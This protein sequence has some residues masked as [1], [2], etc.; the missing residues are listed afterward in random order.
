MRLGH[1]NYEKLDRMMNKGLV[2]GLP[3]FQ[4]QS[5]LVCAGCQYG[6][7][8]QLPYKPATVHSKGPLD[9]VHTDVF[10]PVNKKSIGGMVYMIEFIDDY[11]KFVWVYFMQSKSEALAKFKEFRLVAERE[12]GR[13]VKVLRSDNGGEYMS[14]EFN[15]FL[16]DC[17]IGRQL[18]CPYTPQQNG[19]SER[20]NRHLAEVSGSLMHSKNVPGQFWA[21]AMQTAAYVTNRLPQQ[22]L[23]FLTPYEKLYKVKPTVSHFRVFGCV[24][25]VFVPNN[26]RH[27]LE[28][29]AIRCI[30]VGY[31]NQR[32][33]WKCCD[34]NT[35]KCYVS[36]NV[37]FDETSSWWSAEQKI[38]PDSQP[39]QDELQASKVDLRFEVTTPDEEH[40]ESVQHQEG[41]GVEELP[42]EESGLRRS[43]RIRRQNPRYANVAISEETLR[44]PESFEEASKHHGWMLAMES[45][46]AALISNQTWELVPLPVDVKPIT[47]KW[48][49]KIKR[50][51]D[52]TVERL[53]ARLV[54][55][56]FTQQ[57]GFDYE[58]TFS[59]V[60]KITTVRMILALAV[61][62][63]W[64]LYQMDVH[65]AFLYGELDHV[66]HMEQPIGFV[67]SEH[68]KIVCKLKKAIYGLKQSP[69]AWYGKISE[70]LEHNGFASTSADASLFVKVLGS[71][72]AIVLVYVDDL[73]I[74]GDHVEVITQLKENLKTRF[75]M[76]D[77]GLLRHF[78]GLEVNY[79]KNGLLLH[80]SQYV[81]DLIQRFRME[82]S[83]AAAT[84]FEPSLRLCPDEGKEAEDVTEYRQMIGSLIYLTLTRPDISFAVG[85]LS[86]FMQ[87]PRKPHVF[88]ARRI[89]RYL[90]A[91]TGVGI[92]FTKTVSPELVGF[93]D[94]DYAGDLSMRRSTTGYVFMYG[95][96]PISWS[97]KLQPTVSLSTAE[98]EYRAAAMAA[99][100]LVWLIQ[101]LKDT[102]QRVVQ[103]VK[104][105]SDNRSAIQ[106]A[107]NPTFHARTKHIE[108]H[109]HFVREK[110]LT[111]DIAL[112]Y[113]DTNDQVADMLTKGL[114]VHKLKK[115]CK[116]LGL[117]SD[118]VEGEC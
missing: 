32:K 98:A 8:H 36:R 66:I 7:A 60:A 95:M 20:K 97:S 104:L 78:L 112:E 84:P 18:T 41:G 6:K 117:K 50:K 102:G 59:P 40:D 81:K 72:V 73:I 82:N 89:L 51:T 107:E 86:I 13:K 108:V 11:S 12:T 64:K 9:L 46:V 23:N 80:Q 83:K 44:E 69:R 110:V 28:K 30:F 39:L 113:V 26:L 109:Y 106:L 70:F 63:D 87:A 21:E 5:G 45:E 103:P 114:P 14:R 111:G 65:N 53:K 96:S 35:G 16:N 22:G 19:V 33:G 105:C 92:K 17:Q 2:N 4:V 88:A 67:N 90:N 15:D 116:F 77:L 58:D 71:K 29:K 101:L 38:L 27:K 10:G 55:R 93:C 62:Q 94:S 3:K 91:T 1:V 37:V 52:G 34:P 76:K 43:T 57:F 56:G 115:F 54:A 24:C 75:K 100:E 47:C 61:N 42:F 74:T 68:P 79:K 49:Y 99:Q 118:D 25:Y 48:V 31:D 85:V